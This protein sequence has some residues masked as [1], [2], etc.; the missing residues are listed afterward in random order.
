MEFNSNRNIY[1]RH[2]EG[3]ELCIFNRSFYLL[4]FLSND[5]SAEGGAVCALWQIAY[6][7]NLA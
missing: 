2:G 4:P 3:E 6:Q 5:S 7:P 1:W